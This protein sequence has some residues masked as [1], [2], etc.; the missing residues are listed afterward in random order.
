MATIL[1]EGYTADGYEARVQLVDGRTRTL[2]WL[3]KP[4]DVPAAVDKAE[5][6][7]KWGE[8]SAYRRAQYPREDDPRWLT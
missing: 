3:S 2:H 7:L 5:V 8:I 6:D 1:S 4:A